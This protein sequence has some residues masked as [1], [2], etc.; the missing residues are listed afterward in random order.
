M[1]LGK[2]VGD[3]LEDAASPITERV[4]EIITRVKKI[5]VLL[6]NID[7]KLKQLQPV[8]DLLKKFRLL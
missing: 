2:F 7:N 8:I 4:D 3:Q 1:D 6:V 5:E